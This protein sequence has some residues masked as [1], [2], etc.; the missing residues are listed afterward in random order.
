MTKENFPPLVLGT[1]AGWIHRRATSS[2]HRG[3]PLDLARGNEQ[4]D[5]SDS[6][7]MFFALWAE[8]ISCS[9]PPQTE[10]RDVV[11]AG[12]GCGLTSSDFRDGGTA[13]CPPSGSH[14]GGSIVHGL[15]DGSF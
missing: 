15:K 12:D 1:L 13:C 3:A 6:R 14:H 4:K 11:N 7:A 2:G 10:R 5:A 8:F 9:V